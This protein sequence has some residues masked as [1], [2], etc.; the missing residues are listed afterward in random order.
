MVW[1]FDE[2]RPI[3][4]QLIEEFR[5]KIAAGELACGMKLNSV[6]NLAT[7]IGVNPNTM[8]RALSELEREGLLITQRTAGRFVTEDKEIIKALRENMAKEKLDGLIDGM[9]Q[10]GYEKTEI[11]EFVQTYL[12]ELK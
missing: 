4:L 12:K 2:N 5:L 11:I 6:R 8:Q 7:E 9:L 10:M 3:Y 1:Y